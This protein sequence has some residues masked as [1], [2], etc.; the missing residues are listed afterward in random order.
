M[1]YDDEITAGTSYSLALSD[2]VVDGGI[3]YL[4]VDRFCYRFFIP[5]SSISGDFL[6]NGYQLKHELS[7][8]DDWLFVER[9]LEPHGQGSLW[10]LNASVEPGEDIYSQTIPGFC[11]IDH[12]EVWIKMINDPGIPF[13]LGEVEIKLLLPDIDGYGSLALNLSFA[14][15]APYVA[16][17]FPRIHPHEAVS[18]LVGGLYAGRTLRDVLLCLEAF[19]HSDIGGVEDPTFSAKISGHTSDAL[20]YLLENRLISSFSSDLELITTIRDCEDEHYFSGFIKSLYASGSV[21]SARKAL[22]IDLGI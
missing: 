20:E 17:Y 13:P 7:E 22:H 2:F 14:A 1:T 5:E 21:K 15:V 4:V 19:K 3:R 18:S 9:S 6:L 11:E 12:D 8:C 10:G 16:M